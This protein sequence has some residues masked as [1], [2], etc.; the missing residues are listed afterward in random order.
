MGQQTMQ[1][2]IPSDLAFSDL[3]LTRE[4]DGSVSFDWNVIEQICEAN[5]IAPET[6][7]DAPE[8]NVA[9]LLMG[10]YYKHRALGGESDPVAESLATEVAMEELSGRTIS[11]PPGHA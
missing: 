8:E 1:I 2:E 3:H 4:P 6:F 11:H 10:W 9:N 7:M 5:D